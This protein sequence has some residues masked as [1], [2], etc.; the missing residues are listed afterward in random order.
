MSILANVQSHSLLV[1][2]EEAAELIR[3][4]PRTVWTL[5]K[6]GELGSIKQGRR[7]LIPR[8]ELEN[9]IARKTRVGANLGDAR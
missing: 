9:W 2:Y 7:V 4:C 8:L 5:V 1:S 6:S 3:L